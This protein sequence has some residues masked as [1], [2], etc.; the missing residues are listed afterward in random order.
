MRR[1]K[2]RLIGTVI[3]RMIGIL[4]GILLAYSCCFLAFSQLAQ[5]ADTPQEDDGLQPPK[6][7]LPTTAA[8][9]HYSLSLTV[10][11]DHDTFTGA[12]D[13][14]LNFKDASSV[15][16]LN[17]DKLTVSDATL[18]VNGQ[19]ISAK[20][21]PQ[22][23]DLVGFSFEHPVGPGPAKLHVNYQGEISRKDMEGIF[24]V[25][26]GDHWYIYS[27]FENISARRA[28]PCFDE[29]GYKVP[30][31]V[32][33]NVPSEDGA[34]S[35]TPQLSET[36]GSS[37][38]KTVKFAETKP[39]PSYLVAIAVGPFD[40]VE[41]G[42]AGAKNTAIRIIVPRG[43]GAE[44]KYV[45]ATT[46]DIVN[47]LEKYFAI[48]YPYEKLDE[49][50]IPLAGYAMEHPGLVTYGAGFF[51]MKSDEETLDKKH[52][53]TSVMAHEL[54]HQWFGDLVTTAWWEDIWLNEGF[55]SWMANKIV[56][57]YRPEWKM[58]IDELDSY[59]QAMDTDAL[60]SSRKVRQEILSD[61]DIANAFDGITYSK[62]SSL[63][64][65]FESYMGRE[66]FREGVQAYLKKYSWGNATSADFLASIGGGDPAIAKA[67][68]TFLDQ[69]G[70][71]LVKAHL[72]CSGGSPELQLSQQR[73]LPR[74]S[75]G[76][77][78][79]LWDIPVCVRYPTGDNNKNKDGRQCTLVTAKTATL[80]LDEAKGCPAWTY[81]NAN[82]AGYYRV[83]YDG[84]MLASISKDE[85]ALA[86]TERVGLVGD[87]AALTN[88]YMPLGEA[89][90]LAPK[91]A[92]D[93]NREV[94]TK[95]LNAVGSLDE[96][97]V[98][99]ALM[100]KYR[101]YLSDMF[102]AR[103]EQLGWKDKPGED[104]DTRLLRPAIV[105]A[106]AIHA[107]NPAM[108][109]QAKKLAW[110][111]LDDR[112][113][114]DTDMLANVMITAARHGDRALFDRM[115]EQ[116]KK[117]TDETARATLLAAMGAFRDPTILKTAH[118]IVLTDEFQPRESMNIFFATSSFPDT[119]ELGYEFVKQ[120]WDALI[121]KLPTDFGAVLPYAAVGFCDTQHRTDAEAFFKDR[122]TKVVGAPRNLAQ[123]LES[124][125]L[126][127]ANKEANEP[128]VVEFLTKY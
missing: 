40:I 64:N 37:G 45:A 74:G 67:F 56:N 17:A 19:T 81:D 34:F 25:K 51:L 88:G 11:P 21:L 35:N 72:S 6:F 97:L 122:V 90:A 105:G 36:P 47:L 75:S 123:V 7:R 58:N 83:L 114:V 2:L 89:M 9:Q 31:Q 113:S 57:E 100:P 42:H 111:W 106:V 73:F 59:Q 44:A 15:L 126:C 116:A 41:A 23:K 49:V 85:K 28:F 39:L 99:E 24:Q 109:E 30:W 115:H 5:A 63:L 32:T 60:V 80:R 76:S 12:V 20:V 112:K 27:Q 124:I 84:D 117:E 52:T 29:P 94:V 54:A 104:D 78:D 93:P 53:I 46:P 108:I 96:H 55:A 61:D 103:A 68:S 48:P 38:M 16:W 3:G 101:R 66:K 79:Q 125:S 18:T 65:M 98:P 120:N 70:V 86:L 14:D 127:A 77:A 69:P 22:P 43:R 33:L 110:A 92:H 91:F 71:P 1:E 8:P 128:S 121:A 62:G 82:S 50:A 10:A 26:D 87:I 95:T 119:R 13:I 118:A 4:T 107:E 102:L